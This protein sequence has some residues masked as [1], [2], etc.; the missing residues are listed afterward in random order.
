M[1]HYRVVSEL[2]IPIDQVEDAKELF[3]VTRGILNGMLLHD[4]C[5]TM[6]IAIFSAISTAHLRAD[7][8][9][10]DVSKSN[11]MMTE[12]GGPDGRCGILIDWDH[13]KRI[14]TKR[15]DWLILRTVCIFS[16]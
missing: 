14:G 15:T 13:A 10:R 1:I 6:L 11:T 5:T 3:F 12:E 4:S 8:S 7:T 9:H 16:L 2:L